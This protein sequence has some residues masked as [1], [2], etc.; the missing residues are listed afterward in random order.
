[1]YIS[2]ESSDAVGKIA[3]FACLHRQSR[4]VCK[5][6]RYIVFGL[7]FDHRSGIE[8]RYRGVSSAFKR[9]GTV[10]A[11]DIHGIRAGFERQG[12][13]LALDLYASC[14]RVGN[15]SARSGIFQNEINSRR[16]GNK[17]A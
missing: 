7:V 8:Y 3:G 12:N 10:L 16:F 2:T 9:N 13:I 14:R 4:A 6:D 1:M 11:V 5:C 15:K 17:A